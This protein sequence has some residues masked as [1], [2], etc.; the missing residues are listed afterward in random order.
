MESVDHWTVELEE[1]TNSLELRT[2]SH[3]RYHQGNYK[4]VI[5]L[6]AI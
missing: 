6:G 3:A 2:L 5:I 1:S 4:G